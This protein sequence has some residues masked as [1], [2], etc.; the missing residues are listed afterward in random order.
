MLEVVASNMGAPPAAN[1]AAENPPANNTTTTNRLIAITPA[2]DTFIA[3]QSIASA[4]PDKPTLANALAAALNISSPM[5]ADVVNPHNLDASKFAIAYPY[6]VVKLT[7]I[8]TRFCNNNSAPLMQP[9]TSWVA[10]IDAALKAAASDGNNSTADAHIDRYAGQLLDCHDLDT[11]MTATFGT[12]DVRGR[13]ASHGL[14]TRQHIAT[15]MVIH[16]LHSAIK[17]LQDAFRHAATATNLSTLQLAVLQYLHRSGDNV[18]PAQQ[19]QRAVASYRTAL[20]TQQQGGQQHGPAARTARAYNTRPTRRGQ[21]RLQSQTAAQRPIPGKGEAVS[22]YVCDTATNAVIAMMAVSAENA[23]KVNEAAHRVVPLVDAQKC[24]SRLNLPGK[25]GLTDAVLGPNR[26]FP[27]DAGTWVNNPAACAAAI[28]DV[29]AATMVA[30]ACNAGIP[31]KIVRMTSAGLVAA[32]FCEYN[33]D[34]WNWPKQSALGQSTPVL[35]QWQEDHD[36]GRLY[37]GTIYLVQ[38]DDK[39][40]Y[41]VIIDAA[42]S[43]PGVHPANSVLPCTAA[44]LGLLTHDDMH[45]KILKTIA[46]TKPPGAI[47]HAVASTA[48]VPTVSPSVASVLAASVSA[49]P[50]SAAPVSAASDS[51]ALDTGDSWMLATPSRRKHSSRRSSAPHNKV[52]ATSA[53]AIQATTSSVPA[54]VTLP[55]STAVP[56][57]DQMAAGAKRAAPESALSPADESRRADQRDL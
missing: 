5:Y 42:I 20:G 56:D 52:P 51:A 1:A 24:F 54:V 9:P 38:S 19:Q 53:A 23:A 48:S 30:V 47:M 35:P 10:R 7:E 17:E 14:D 28:A 44:S 2:I 37:R 12:Q 40:K 18:N 46:A 43:C 15:E 22:T 29:R 33:I 50:V 41:E 26:T 39:D 13:F 55:Q 32:P 8:L 3:K 36:G 49:A 21:V 11:L 45:G 57:A 27:K 25:C 16:A 31:I 34:K 6:I 4:T